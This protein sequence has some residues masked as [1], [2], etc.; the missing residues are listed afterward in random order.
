MENLP[1]DMIRKIAMDLRVQKIIDLCRT[2]RRAYNAVCTNDRFWTD[3]ARERLTA[4][5]ILLGGLSTSEIK[6]Q[7]VN[8][9]RS[10]WSDALRVA[11]KKGFEKYIAYFTETYPKVPEVRYYA[12]QGAREGHNFHL[13]Q[14]LYPN[15]AIEYQDRVV[16]SIMLDNDNDSL[17]VILP[18][19][20]DQ[21]LDILQMLADGV[22]S[23]EISV[24]IHQERIRRGLVG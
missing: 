19:I 16:Y 24:M 14:L 21:Q 17:R 7:L 12:F 15:M 6:R 3:L 13:M 4:D 10:Y 22:A 11:G 23:N 9:E 20:L 5:P 1:P 2:N 8:L 18:L